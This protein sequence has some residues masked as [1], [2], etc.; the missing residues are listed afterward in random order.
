LNGNYFSRSLSI[1]VSNALVGYAQ[2]IISYSQVVLF[3]RIFPGVQVIQKS[4]APVSI[5]FVTFSSYLSEFRHSFKESSSAQSF[6]ASAIRNFLLESSSAK[7]VSIS[8]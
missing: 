6:T 5:C 2:D 4:F 1:I 7:D 3:I 8:L